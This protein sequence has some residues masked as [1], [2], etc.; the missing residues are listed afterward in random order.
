MRL[1]AATEKGQCGAGEL[2]CAEEVHVKLPTPLRSGDEL[3]RPGDDDSGV[4]DKDSQ[5]VWSGEIVCVGYSSVDGGLV[6]YVEK[7]GF[8]TT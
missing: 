3:D 8:E 5:T 1:H 4:V 6:G 2:D 7:R